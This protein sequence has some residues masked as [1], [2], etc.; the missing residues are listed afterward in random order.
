M[1]QASPIALDTALAGSRKEL[2]AYVDRGLDGFYTTD[3]SARFLT[4]RG[5][6]T[7]KRHFG[8]ITAP[9]SGLGPRPDRVFGGRN[10]WRGH[11]LIAWATSRSHEEEARARARAHSHG[12]E[13]AA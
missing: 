5:F 2:Y 12:K 1:S 3:Q 13:A 10:L 11:T 6:P 4:D 7:Q 8:K 9:G